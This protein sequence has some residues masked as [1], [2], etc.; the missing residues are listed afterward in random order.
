PPGECLPATEIF[1]RLSRK[2]GLD[3]PALYESDETMA[4]LILESGHPSLADITLEK[5]KACGWMRLNYPNPFVPFANGFPSPAGQIEVV[6]DPMAQAGLHP[7]AG[8]T[9]SYDSSQRDIGL[10]REYPLS[11]VTP[12]N[13]YF[14][15]STFANVPRQQQRA[16]VARLL[17][18]HH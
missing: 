18:H 7:V 17:I 16:G 3:E 2:M 13:H 1:R 9:A 8:Y 6:F 10:A 12:A 15:N 14:L 4:R 11:L 5:L